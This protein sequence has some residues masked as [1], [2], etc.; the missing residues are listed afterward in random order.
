[1]KKFSQT[2]L[3]SGPFLTSP[4]DPVA[5]PRQPAA[6]SL[7]G[8][9]SSV[10]SSL[11]TRPAQDRRRARPFRWGNLTSSLG[12][13]IRAAF[14]QLPAINPPPFWK[15]GLL[16]NKGLRR[17]S[18]SS[19]DAWRSSPVCGTGGCS[20]IQ[21]GALFLTAESLT[22]WLGWQRQH[23]LLLHKEETTG[24]AAKQPWATCP[25]RWR[26]CSSSPPWSRATLPG[27]GE[28]AALWKLRCT[29]AA[30]NVC[31]GGHPCPSRHL[32]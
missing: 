2:P 8:S 15:E 25:T 3:V 12:G 32:F 10:G 30:H 6:S 9:S 20:A 7:D 24:T 19:G 16:P 11:E 31:R 17:S 21:L 22:F 26:Q 23:Q 1:M 27:R 13:C 5:H 29:A 14:Q 28:S 18:S 4:C